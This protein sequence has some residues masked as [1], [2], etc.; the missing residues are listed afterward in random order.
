M[1]KYSCDKCEMQVEALRCGKC[2]VTLENRE[3][4]VQGDKVQVA[5]CPSGCGKV[6]SPQCCGHDMAFKKD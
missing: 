1:S 3:I 6:K 4:E 5:E 2:G